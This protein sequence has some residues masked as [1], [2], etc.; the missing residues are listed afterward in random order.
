MAVPFAPKSEEIWTDWVILQPIPFKSDRLL[1]SKTQTSISCVRHAGLWQKSDSA[2]RPPTNNFHLL[3][4][5]PHEGAIQTD[6]D[7]TAVLK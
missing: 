1:G 5:Q 6:V 4:Q 7:Y 3:S 2:K